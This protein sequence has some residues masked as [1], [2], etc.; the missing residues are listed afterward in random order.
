MGGI[1]AAQVAQIAITKIGTPPIGGMPTKPNIGVN[2]GGSP[3]MSADFLGMLGAMFPGLSAAAG[4]FL[5]GTFKNLALDLGLDPKNLFMSSPLGPITK[6]LGDTVKSAVSDLQLSANIGLNAATSEFNAAV[7]AVKSTADQV[8]GVP[9]TMITDIA[10]ENLIISPG[11]QILNPASLASNIP[12]TLA[13]SIAIDQCIQQS[14][15]SILLDAAK[16]DITN[17][18]GKIQD[19]AT[20]TAKDLLGNQLKTTMQDYTGKL[21]EQVAGFENA[22]ADIN[23]SLNPVA[24]MSTQVLPPSIN[25]KTAALISESANTANLSPDALVAANNIAGRMS[26]TVLPVFKEEVLPT[27]DKQLAME[28]NTSITATTQ[29]AAAS[30]NIVYNNKTGY[31]DGVN[32]RYDA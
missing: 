23:K 18:V 24:Y 1:S 15:S 30:T 4:E 5:S 21:N 17:I 3:A 19:A 14:T 16:S 20:Q 9:V 12:G 6:E 28:A 32:L 10:P 11:A 7:A 29:L 31:P 25:V 8:L 26:N 22:A 2:I 27:I 13:N